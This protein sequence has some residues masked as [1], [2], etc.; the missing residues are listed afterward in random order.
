M[1]LEECCL[2]K[3]SWLPRFAYAALTNRCGARALPAVF[4]ALVL[5]APT[6]ILGLRQPERSATSQEPENPPDDV[7][8]VPSKE[9]TLDKAGQQHYFLVG[10]K[11]G[12]SAPKAGYRLL[13]V[14][15]GGDGGADFN[16]FVKRVFK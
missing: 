11:K 3:K 2:P 14:L 4:L 16:P 13:L 10:P 6:P 9:I 15:P 7:A 12:K 8:D 5:A 1:A